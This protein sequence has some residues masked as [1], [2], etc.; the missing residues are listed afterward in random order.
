MFTIAMWTVFVGYPSPQ[1]TAILTHLGNIGFGSYAVD[2]VKEGRDLIET[3]GFE[4]V[5]ALEKLDDGI[6]YDL[7]SPVMKQGGSLFIG[8]ETS[9]E[10]LWLHVVDHGD[11]ALGTSAMNHQLLE[12]ELVDVLTHRSGR[13]KMA[14]RWVPPAPPRIREV[15][16]SVLSASQIVA[17]EECK[18]QQI[19]TMPVPITA[20]RSLRVSASRPV[21]KRADAETVQGI[22]NREQT[23][24]LD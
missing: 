18:K 7:V 19:T 15:S 20:L 21:E 1:I 22:Q 6:G 16:P 24:R 4:L 17:R 23:D 9:G 3:G 8:L 14:S 11:K 5:L 12:M 10:C 13:A 2:C